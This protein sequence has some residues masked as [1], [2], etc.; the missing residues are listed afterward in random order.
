MTSCDH[1]YTPDPKH[2]GYE[3]CLKCRSSHSRVAPRPELVYTADYW[4][5]ERS[6]STLEEQIYNVNEYAENGKTKNDAIL[7]S[8][9]V[10]GRNAALEIGCAPGSL[11]KRLNR[12]AGF[13]WVCGIDAPQMDHKAIREIA[14]SEGGCITTVSGFFPTDTLARAEE[15]FDLIVSCDCYEH[16]H[17]PVEF[18]AECARLLKPD[19]ELILML[20]LAFDDMPE[21]MWDSQEHVYLHSLA[22]MEQLIEGAGLRLTKISRWTAGHEIIC[23][24]HNA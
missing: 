6:H 10:T 15:R 3:Y 19:G 16:S 5:H 21:R 20:P 11:M 7:D 2:E 4:S 17:E 1:H 22:H 24:R 23:A 18:M 8:I 9:T 13:A 12:D 14:G